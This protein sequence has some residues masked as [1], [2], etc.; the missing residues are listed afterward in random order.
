[1]C[2]EGFAEAYCNW[3]S[4]FRGELDREDQLHQEQAE[5]HGNQ[6]MQGQG[7]SSTLFAS[8]HLHVMVLNGGAP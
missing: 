7:L 8:A 4:F 2:L 1:M 6:R 3:S 5:R